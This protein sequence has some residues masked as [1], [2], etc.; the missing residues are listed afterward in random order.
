MIM[1]PYET[2]K[3]ITDKI[4]TC[5]RKKSYGD[6]NILNFLLI[7]RVSRFTL[8]MPILRKCV[9]FY[10]AFLNYH[11]NIDKLQTS[12]NLLDYKNQKLMQKERLQRMNY[13]SH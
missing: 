3:A 8:P 5:K 1:N 10:F 4:L 11:E 13:L 6:I 9:E 2:V 12:I 7:G